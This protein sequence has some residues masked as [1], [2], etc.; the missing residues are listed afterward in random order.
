MG[1][2][3][4]PLLLFFLLFSA[5]IGIIEYFTREG[6]L[7]AES[8]R[9]M[10][11]MSGGFGSL[12]FPF[13]IQNWV[14]VLALAL[15][16]V[17]T[18]FIGEK[19]KILTSLC[20]VERKSIGAMLFPMAILFLFI[21]ADGRAWLYVSSLLVLTLADTGAALV[22]T[23]YGKIHFNTGHG[24]KSLEGCITF[25]LIGFLAVHLPLLLL[26][27]IPR[28]TTVLVGI[29]MAT[30]LSGV[31]AISIGGTDNIFVPIATAFM[32]QK[33]TSK[34]PIELLFQSS[35]LI[36]LSIIILVLNHRKHLMEIRP[37]I[38]L[39]LISFASWSLGSAEWIIP[40]ISGVI[41]HL[42]LFKTME[43]IVDDFSV[44]KLMWPFLPTMLILFTANLSMTHSF[45]YGTFM[46]VTT[47][48][49][50][51][52][53]AGRLRCSGQKRSIPN[54]IIIMILPVLST[55]I[56]LLPFEGIIILPIIPISLIISISSVLLYFSISRYKNEKLIPITASCAGILFLTLQQFGF[57]SELDPFTWQEIFR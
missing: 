37:A 41:T 13:F 42:V 19:K 20:N 46:T 39:I 26:S 30:L 7:Q 44:Q 49:V 3:F 55:S 38:F 8:A 6:K 22:G 10:V 18:I 50:S 52:Y 14:T 27:D 45:W 28:E 56:M 15:L 17:T 4:T 12:L 34:P 48:S 9:K 43:P 33:M 11:H 57:I 25:W 29:L 40:G 36:I 1:I 24:E 23:H 5:S 51:L 2:E 54:T 16:F 35:S 47:T 53:L 31:E 21:A 32:L